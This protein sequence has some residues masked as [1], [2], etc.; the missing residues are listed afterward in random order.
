MVRGPSPGTLRVSLPRS[1]HWQMAPRALRRRATSDR[2][3][4]RRIR[5]DRAAG[6]PQR[7]P[8]ARYFS[9]CVGAAPKRPVKEPPKNPPQGPKRATGEGTSRRRSLKA[10]RTRA[11]LG[12]TVPA[13]LRHLVR[14]AT[15]ICSDAG[16]GAP[17]PQNWRRIAVVPT[18]A[19]DPEPSS[20][21]PERGH[22]GKWPLSDAW[23]FHGIPDRARPHAEPPSSSSGLTPPGSPWRRRGWCVLLFAV[24]D[25]RIAQTVLEG[26]EPGLVVP[27]LQQ[28]LTEDRLADLL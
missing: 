22:R 23:T 12:A 3:T 4:P 6:D 27:P 5:G 28:P 10:R 26:A 7:D 20:D 9:P 17:L 14:K 15:P 11:V 1:A 21:F 24:A 13:A 2:S 19:S 18:T 16:S 8:H 25:Q